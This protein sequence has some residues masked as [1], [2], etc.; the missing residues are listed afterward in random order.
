[1][2]RATESR[3]ADR[4]WLSL[5]GRSYRDLQEFVKRAKSKLELQTLCLTEETFEFRQEDVRYLLRDEMAAGNSP[6]ADV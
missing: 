1:V 3:M 2:S 5:Y 6:T 4:T